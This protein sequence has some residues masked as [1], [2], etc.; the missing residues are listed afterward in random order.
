MTNANTNA[1]V[2]VTDGFPQLAI[3]AGTVRHRRLRPRAH[4]FQ[5]RL[6]MLWREAEASNAPPLSSGRWLLPGW[7]RG[8]YLRPQTPSLKEAARQAAQE[9]TGAAGGGDVYVLA[10]PRQ[11]GVSYNPASFYIV[12]D[13][14]GE[15]E[16]LL[17]EVDNTP[18]R[19]RFCYAAPF[20]KTSQM[21]K[22]GHVSPFNPMSMRYEWRFT[23]PGARFCVLMKCIAADGKADMEVLM[24]L[25]RLPFS[26]RNLW[27]AALAHPFSAA[28]NSVAI[29]AHAFRL[30]CKG[31]PVYS[32]PRANGAKFFGGK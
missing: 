3:Y 32:H 20:G 26:R 21:Q 5:R 15:P 28:A 22:R 25:R 14:A 2:A 16:T 23:R 13:A 30:F 10:Q 4:I 6:F 8:D 1:T 24:S 27:R 11:F 12:C 9:I 29:Y 18:W 7:R 17:V 31:A 19:E